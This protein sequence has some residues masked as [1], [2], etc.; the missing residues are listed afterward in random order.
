MLCILLCSCNSILTSNIE[1]T[2]TLD[3]L[4]PKVENFI[5]EIFPLLFDRYMT[6]VNKIDELNLELIELEKIYR[7]LRDDVARSLIAFKHEELKQR[8][9]ELLKAKCNLHAEFEYIMVMYKTKSITSITSNA[10][11]IL[12]DAEILLKEAS[13]AQNSVLMR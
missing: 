3:E 6:L 12:R 1:E 8:R 9:D 13:K 7:N 11:N 4:S 5:A 2:R 10:E